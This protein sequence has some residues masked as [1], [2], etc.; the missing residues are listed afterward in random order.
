MDQVKARTINSDVPGQELID[1]N[2]PASS[3]TKSASVG[4]LHAIDAAPHSLLLKREE[5]GLK[6]G[7][8]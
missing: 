3:H 2:I 4:I 7:L 8:E 5:G 6:E 1:L